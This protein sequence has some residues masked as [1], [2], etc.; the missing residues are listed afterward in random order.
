M[1]ESIMQE[2]TQIQPS[3]P[4][5]DDAQMLVQQIVY[6]IRRLMQAGEAYTKELNKKYQISV[7]QL[8]CLMA[9]YDNGPLSASTIA[10]HIL[11]KSSTVT[12]IIDRL[13]LKGLVTRSR[14]RADRRVITIELTESGKALAETGP[15]PIQDRL[16]EGLEKL[17]TNDIQQ[18]VDSFSVLTHLLD[19]Q[20]LPES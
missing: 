3:R 10:K 7:P 17:K 6:N 11:V 8:N 19:I 12:G 9:L 14:N 2:Q 20:E 18:I 15:P 4:A 16:M 13:E 5:D 1:V